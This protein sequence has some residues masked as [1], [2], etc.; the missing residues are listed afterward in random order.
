MIA[1][2]PGG[3]R[4]GA[5]L[6]ALIALAVCGEQ[7]AILARIAR[8]AV[9][10]LRGDFVP[11][12]RMR[13]TRRCGATCCLYDDPEVITVMGLQFADLLAGTIVVER[14]LPAEGWGATSSSQ[15]DRVIV[16]ATA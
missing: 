8:S 1:E 10:V 12:A 13:A 15:S 3:R 5:A 14:V 11:R 4:R 2:V 16:C 9:L 6:K 7:A